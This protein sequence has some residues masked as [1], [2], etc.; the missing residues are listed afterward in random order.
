[1]GAA[2]SSL[3]QAPG[4]LDGELEA[5]PRGREEGPLRRNRRWGPGPALRPGGPPHLQGPQVGRLRCLQVTMWAQETAG[6]LEQGRAGPGH[7]HGQPC[8]GSL[9]MPLSPLCSS[10]CQGSHGIGGARAGSGA[11]ATGEGQVGGGVGRPSLLGLP[12]LPLAGEPGPG[13][14]LQPCPWPL[15]SQNALPSPPALLRSQVTPAD[16]GWMVCLCVSEQVQTFPPAQVLPR[17]CLVPAPVPAGHPQRG[18][19]VLVRHGSR[20]RLPKAIEKMEG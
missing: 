2:C 5:H 17:T 8:P 18:L 16:Q 12:Q 14:Q 19:Q 20:S 15:S 4:P 7:P 11:A 13:A 1:M 9:G 3:P 10:S 6:S